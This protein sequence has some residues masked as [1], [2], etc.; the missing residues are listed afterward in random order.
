MDPRH[1]PLA[2]FKLILRSNPEKCHNFLESMVDG[3]YI[4]LLTKILL[5]NVR[6]TDPRMI[7]VVIS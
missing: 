2:E 4:S 7:N 5:T 1:C 3:L 6:E